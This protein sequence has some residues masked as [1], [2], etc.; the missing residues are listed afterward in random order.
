[1]VVGSSPTAVT[2]LM[3]SMNLSDISIL[4]IKG[5][6]YLLIIFSIGI[7]LVDVHLD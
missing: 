2:L 1:M 4:I 6:S 5:L 7:T 3:M